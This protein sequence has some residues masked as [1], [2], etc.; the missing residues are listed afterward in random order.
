[1]AGNRWPV[2]VAGGRTVPAA[3]TRTLPIPL[4]MSWPASRNDGQIPKSNFG[5]RF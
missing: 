5:K 3:P 2:A 1:M 4:P